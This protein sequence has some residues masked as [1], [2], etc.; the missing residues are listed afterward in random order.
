ME[1]LLVFFMG[2]KG[3]HHPDQ[4]DFVTSKFRLPRKMDRA[5]FGAKGAPV[6]FGPISRAK[7][8]QGDVLNK[9]EVPQKQE[10]QDIGVGLGP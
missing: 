2:M 7:Q 1:E 9:E 5:G 8:C 10:V 6:P 4:Q 3:N